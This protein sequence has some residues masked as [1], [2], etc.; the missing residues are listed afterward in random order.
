MEKRAEIIISGRV[1]KTGF[2]DFV[3]EIAFN[4]DLNGYVKNL[5]NGTVQIISEGKVDGIKEL[6]EKI[7][8]IQYPIHVE[9]IDV[10]YK[11]PTGEYRTFEIIS[12]EDLTTATYERLEVAVR[13]M[14]EMNSNPGQ[15][16]DGPGDKIDGLGD[17]FEVDTIIS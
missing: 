12:E 13:Y 16:I 15:K 9:N 6:L 3:D 4:L 11:K 8:I 7:N 17:N 5:D 14:K 1:Q 10:V 2:R